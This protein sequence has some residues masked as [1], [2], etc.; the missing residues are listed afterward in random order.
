MS[1]VAP[2]GK[3]QARSTV[4]TP[5][6]VTAYQKDSEGYSRVPVGGFNV[7]NRAGDF[8][9]AKVAVPQ[10]LGQVESTLGRYLADNVLYGEIDHPPLTEF[11]IPGVTQRVALAR[12]LQ[13]LKVLNPRLTSHHIKSFDLEVAGDGDWQNEANAV[14]VWAWMLPF[15][16]YKQMIE[17]SFK[18]PSINTYFSLRSIVQP[19]MRGA[20]RY[21]H[22]HDICTY[23]NVSFGGKANACKH[24]AVA[25]LN[26][27]I[28][29]LPDG[30]SADF[31]I[32]HLELAKELCGQSLGM[33]HANIALGAID[34]LLD[35]AYTDRDSRIKSLNS[36]GR[37]NVPNSG[38]I[39]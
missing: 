31:E 35:R 16:P 19:E 22:M 37:F 36:S 11:M 10:I 18:T 4:Y 2:L 28:T 6:S 5:P 20:V 29:L 30:F 1:M 7:A 9:P 21:M 14:R 17:D 27:A 3:F 23:D 38:I 26:S 15:G 12:W 13:R 25:G 8:Y 39:W 32:E 33:E 34:R 24:K